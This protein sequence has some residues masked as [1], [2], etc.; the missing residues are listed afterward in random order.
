MGGLF[1]FLTGIIGTYMKDGDKISEHGFFFGYTPVV[2]AVIFN[3]AFGG[4]LVAVAI[5]YADNILK[6]FACSISICVSAVV[7]YFIFEFEIT[8]LFVVG[9]SAVI[10]AVFMYSLPK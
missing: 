3:Q 2:W 7:A 6:G 9:T 10:C 5:K 4:L 8:F 1:G